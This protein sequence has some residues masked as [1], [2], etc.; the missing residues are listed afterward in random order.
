MREWHMYNKDRN[1]TSFVSWGIKWWDKA[2]RKT[3]E[4]CS[5]AQTAEAQ[6]AEAQAEAQTAEAQTAKAQT[7][8]DNNEMW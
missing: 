4:K 8:E 5:G 3:E 7:A 6:T 2:K 1:S